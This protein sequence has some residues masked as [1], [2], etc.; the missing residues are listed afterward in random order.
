MPYDDPE[1]E[2]PHELVGVVLPA[3]AASVREMACTFAV[4]FA[5]MG[6]SRERILGLFRQPYYRGAHPALQALGEG[7]IERIVDESLR[8][9]GARAYVVR[10][11]DEPARLAGTAGRRSLRVI[12]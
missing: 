9:W 4:E 1:P 5:Q 7:E 8:V 11:A 12:R 2:D 6:F 10:D 3:D